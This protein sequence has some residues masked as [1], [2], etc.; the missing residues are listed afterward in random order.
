M[1]D[2]NKISLGVILMLRQCQ[3]WVLKDSGMYAHLIYSGM[4]YTYYI[5]LAD[6]PGCGSEAV[7][8]RDWCERRVYTKQ[9]QHANYHYWH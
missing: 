4:Q 7:S 9:A 8:H 3:Q 6:S 5:L 1:A 2:P